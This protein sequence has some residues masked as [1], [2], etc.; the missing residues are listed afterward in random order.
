[1]KKRMNHKE[2]S[3]FYHDLALFARSG[4]T[5]ERGLDTLKKGKKGFAFLMMDGIQ[6][7]IARGGSLWE[8][9]SHYPTFFDEFQV[10][11]IKAAETSGELAR[12]CQ[13][14]SRYF[15]VRHK[16][17]RRLLANLIYPVVLLHGVIMLPPLKYL[18]VESLDKSYWAIVLPPLLIAYGI[19]GLIVFA[20]QRF[21]RAGRLREKVDEFLLKLPMIGNLVRGISLVRVIRS[22][23][24]LHN[25]GV[26]VVS[27]ARQAALTAGNRAISLR[28]SAALPVLEQGGSYTDY[29]TFAG[30]LTSSQL[31][32]VAVGEQSGALA[33]SLER[34]VMQMEEDNHQRLTTIIKT[35]IYVVYFIAAAM[36][37]LT[38]I[39]FY[40]GYFNVI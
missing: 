3:Q 34:M 39:S 37:A 10:M 16:E 15:E 32:V 27:T 38:V 11:L 29:F 12:T 2:R 28:L 9:M 26:E 21:F 24:S 8:G 36:V 17:K 30:V 40:S 4:L 5:L 31:G 18:V 14:L 1:M 6:E 22:L 25:A 33:E 7:H 13:G 20:W 23:T 19:L 35:A